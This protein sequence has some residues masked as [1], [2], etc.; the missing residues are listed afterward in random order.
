MTHWT[1]NGAFQVCY[2]QPVSEHP[3]WQHM[4]LKLIDR[5]RATRW[6]PPD[7]WQTHNSNGL[8][9]DIRNYHWLNSASRVLISTCSAPLVQTGERKQFSL[10]DLHPQAS[11]GQGRPSCQKSRSNGSNRRAPTNKWMDATK[12]SIAPAMRSI[13]SVTLMFLIRVKACQALAVH[14]ASSSSHF[15]FRVRTHKVT[16]HPTYTST[17]IAW[18]TNS[19][20]MLNSRCLEYMNGGQYL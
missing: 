15:P 14:Y 20:Q 5:L 18:V 13:I 11:Q 3:Y 19:F 9:I 7:Y 12:C 2:Y 8:V 17:T 1:Q 6:M 16:D 4:Q 10:I